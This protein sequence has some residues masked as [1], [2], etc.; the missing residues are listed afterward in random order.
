MKRSCLT[1][2][3]AAI[4]LAAPAAAQ[5]SS[6]PGAAATAVD[7]RQ[8][9][10]EVRRVIAERYVLP[11]R[12]PALDA[13]L[14]EGLA[15]GRYNVADPTQL[16]ALI[17]ADLERVG[18]DRHLN[19]GYDPAQA[20]QLAARTD[21]G[22]PDRSGYE[23]QVRRNNHGVAELKLLPGNVR[24][25]DYRGFNWI[26][27]ESQAALD[28]AMHFL[29]GGEAVIIDLRRNGGGSPQAVQH[30]ISHFMEPDRPL[31]T[32]HMNGQPTPDSLSSLRELQAPRMIGKP[33]YVLISAG[34]GSAAEEFTG[35]VG[36]YR[37]G[38]LVGANT[39]GAGFRNDLVPVPGGFVLSVSVGRAVLAST[40]KDW[41]A[42]GHAPTIPAPVETALEAAHAHALR[43][44][45]AAAEGE[46]RA[47]LE[48]L[49]EGL[50]AISQ[51]GT[52]AAP[53]A[54]YA[55]SYGERRVWIE[56]GK[57]WYQLAGRPKR[58]LVALGDHRFTF[59]DDPAWRLV[60]HMNGERITAFDSGPAHGPAQGRYERTAG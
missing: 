48:G 57:L 11:E 18:R 21:A 39:S 24:Y 34:T 12:R 31:V 5:P 43:R 54:A 15:S 13:V 19:F 20:A 60:F 29:S 17:N 50:N 7:P 3:A 22:E 2:A 46:R 16:A 47:E 59:G 33:L 49:A 58:P 56:D 38:E 30:I 4:C 14:A 25:M 45:A 44:I 8:V 41:E 36:G 42:V 40:G 23:R 55:G 6:R 37:L 35:H 1:L 10:G 27:P 51:P 9:V 53:I 32:F 52:P 26:G 28:T